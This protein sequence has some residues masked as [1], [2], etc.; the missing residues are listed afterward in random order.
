MKN[1]IISSITLSLLALIGCTTENDILN[2]S[3]SGQDGESVLITESLNEV[4]QSFELEEICGTIMEKSLVSKGEFVGGTLYVANDN[5]QL[6]LIFVAA[7]G[8]MISETHLYFGDFED[9]PSPG[10]GN[11]TISLGQFPYKKH[12]DPPLVEVPMI[13]IPIQDLP[14]DYENKLTIVAHAT[15]VSGEGE[16][17][18]S[19]SVY[20]EWDEW[21]W[22]SGPQWGGGFIYDRQFCEGEMVTAELAAD[23]ETEAVSLLEAT[24]MCFEPVMLNLTFDNEEYIGTVN[25][26]FDA[27]YENLVVTYTLYE[28]SEWDIS[29]VHINIGEL[30]SDQQSKG[31]GRGTNNPVVGKFDYV[32]HLG[33]IDDKINYAYSIPLIELNSDFLDGG[34]EDFIVQATLI[35]EV[36]T[37]G[38]IEEITKS[39]FIE[40]ETSFTG[41]KK[42]GSFELC[43]LDCVE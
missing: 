42:G 40:W 37:D 32:Y 39:A 38:I 43:L 16:D 24:T 1:L 13:S 41:P 27:T 22:F 34:C 29:V 17:L 36:E 20:A 4:P 10:H 23:A 31:K 28:D 2:K 21:L 26:S 12:Y 8:W 30:T 7:E 18:E 33:E 25:F 15:V 9:I 35:S 6:N 5:D 11:G 19:Y 3:F 14:F